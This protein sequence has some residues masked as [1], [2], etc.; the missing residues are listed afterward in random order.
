MWDFVRDMEEIYI[1]LYCVMI[2]WVNISFLKDYKN[3]Q[4]GLG[5]ISSEDELTINPGAWTWLEIALIFTF[6][7][8]WLLYLF[9]VVVIG[10]KV[11]IV[12]SSIGVRL[13]IF[14]AGLAGVNSF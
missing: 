1:I 11:V 5:E 4:R 12:I 8:R 14:V 10:N 2:L 6:F 13:E 7:R 9:A 3:I